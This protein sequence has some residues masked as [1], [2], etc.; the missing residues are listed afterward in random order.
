VS[1]GAPQVGASIRVDHRRT[2][3]GDQRLGAFRL[4]LDGQRVGV[5]M[6]GEIFDLTVTP[7]PHTLRIRQWWYRSP[8]LAVEVDPS[9]VVLLDADVDRSVGAFR[10]FLILLFKPSRAL[11]LAR[12][13]DVLLPGGPMS[14]SRQ[15]SQKTLA[16]TGIGCAACAGLALFWAGHGHLL[17][18]AAS[19]LFMVLCSVVGVLFLLHRGRS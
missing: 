6:P 7:G 1:D 13:P 5:V 12:S 19:L 18:A 15:G 17:L 16:L 14:R 4:S 2:W 3:F 8:P 9:E 11:T 10:R